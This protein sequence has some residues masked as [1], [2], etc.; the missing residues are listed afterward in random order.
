MGNYTGFPRRI[1]YS[2]D[3]FPGK[4][5][6]ARK[7]LEGVVKG[8]ERFLGVERTVVDGERHWERMHAWGVLGNIND[9]LNTVSPLSISSHTL[10]RDAEL[11]GRPT[12]P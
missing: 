2:G 3:A 6:E 7:L 4:D 12:Q 10:Y 9:L 1:F 8:L 11:S 5:T